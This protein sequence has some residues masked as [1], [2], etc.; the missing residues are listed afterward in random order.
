[1]SE[2]T[3]DLAQAFIQSQPA[4][5]AAVLELQPIE[6]VAAF[7]KNTP[8]KQAATVL[9]KML[10]FYLARLSQHLDPSTCAGFFSEMETSLIAAI[11]RHSDKEACGKILALLPERTKLACNILLSYS[12]SAVG[13][14]MQTDFVAIPEDCDASEAR[15]RIASLDIS[16]FN[17][18]YVVDRDRRLKGCISIAHLYQ[19]TEKTPIKA[20]M[21]KPAAVFGR[22]SLLSI[23]NET[24][25]EGHECAAV[26]NKNQQLLGVLRHLDLRRGLKE[27]SNTIKEPQNTDPVAG[28]LEVY[29]SCLLA[30][31]NTIGEATDIKKS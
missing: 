3:S 21:K 12:E 4:S 16:A 9:K 28:I 26:I 31:L 7:L 17:T 8:Y 23:S 11:M 22:S 24:I 19:A 5:A 15:V 1:M 13:A 27:I 29:G 25:W 2:Q 18:L 30:L 20:L 14:W 6:Q 10:P